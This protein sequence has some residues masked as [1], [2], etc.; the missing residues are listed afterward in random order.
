MISAEAQSSPGCGA[1]FLHS[2]VVGCG[3][4]TAPL[5]YH[6]CSPRERTKGES[7]LKLYS[8]CLENCYFPTLLSSDTELLLPGWPTIL[9]LLSQKWSVI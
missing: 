4:Y 7:F 2:P 1:D 5:C 8:I 9:W 3:P 6:R